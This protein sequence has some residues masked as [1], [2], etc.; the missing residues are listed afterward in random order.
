M[1]KDLKYGKLA[2]RKAL[3]AEHAVFRGDSAF[4]RVEPTVAGR[5]PVVLE[6]TRVGAR[7]R[8]NATGRADRL[9]YSGIF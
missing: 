8:L 7:F 1:L 9:E 5:V 2:R 6:F 3:L 4:V